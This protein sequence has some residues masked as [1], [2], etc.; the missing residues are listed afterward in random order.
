[1]KNYSSELEL[2]YDQKP[3]I[4]LKIRGNYI[5][6]S[7]ISTTGFE[8]IRDVVNGNGT[9]VD[10]NVNTT[11]LYLILHD[12]SILPYMLNMPVKQLLPGKMTIAPFVKRVQHL[13]QAP[14]ESNCTNYEYNSESS[15]TIKSRGS[16]II[17]CLWAKLNANK[18]CTNF[19][20]IFTNEMINEKEAHER[21]VRL[22]SMINPNE[23]MLNSTIEID[24]NGV[25]KICPQSKK[26]FKKYLLAKTECLDECPTGCNVETFEDHQMYDIDLDD[27]NVSQIQIYWYPEPVVYIYQTPKWQLNDL[28]GNI[29]AITYF[30]LSFSVSTAIVYVIKFIQTWEIFPQIVCGP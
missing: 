3:R 28:L 11:G 8:N 21:M 1:M 9:T 5:R 7:S 26:S 27:K 16:C 24:L 20:S 18:A 14:Y 12:S 22:R 2:D 19:Y 15:Q 17:T 6:T 13:L 23:S 10:Q 25:I 30:W 4:T 29:G